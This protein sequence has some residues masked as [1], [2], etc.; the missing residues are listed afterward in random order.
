[1]PRPAPAT[2]DDPALSIGFV[3]SYRVHPQMQS[4]RAFYENRRFLIV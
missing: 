2:P 1:L 4:L 3:A